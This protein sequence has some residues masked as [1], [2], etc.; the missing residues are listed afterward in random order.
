MKLEICL[1]VPVDSRCNILWNSVI[2]RTMQNNQ[3][4][5]LEMWV[6]SEFVN[7]FGYFDFVTCKLGE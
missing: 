6:V 4:D 3:V 7:Y 1:F 5:K 2:F